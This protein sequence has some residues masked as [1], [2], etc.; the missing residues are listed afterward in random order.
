MSIERANFD[1]IAEAELNDLVQASVPEGLAIEYKREPYGNSDADKKEA[2]KDISSF[3]NSAGGHLIIGME[4]TNGVATGLRGLP[5]VDPDALITR[6]ESLVRDGVEPR[7]VGVR[8][9]AVRLGRGGAALVIRIPRSWNPPHRVSAARTNRF[10]VRNSGGAHEA[11]VEELRVLFTLAADARKRIETFR[12]HRLAMI[13][14]GAGPLPL[15]RGGRLIIHM[16]PLS[17]VSQAV[18]IDLER[19]FEARFQFRPMTSDTMTRR[20]NLDGVV[21]VNPRED[22][23]GYTQV[24]REGIVEAT[25]SN[26]L[27][28]LSPGNPVC[29]AKQ[30][31][32]EITE[33]IPGYLEGLQ[34]LD[35]PP[36]IVVLVSLQGVAGA[37][38]IVF[39]PAGTVEQLFPSSDPLILPDVV[40]DNYGSPR[41]YLRA[42]K[43]VFD[44]LW[45]AAGFARCM[46]YDADGNWLPQ[47]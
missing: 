47:R 35:V 19:A 15:S 36:P 22:R 41:D 42:L 18:A 12:T 23:P 6:L 25:L 39:N 16:I 3:A 7:I 33:V 24:F 9:R 29:E 11:S 26:I 1:D 38:L 34:A 31:T 14:A 37:K 10:Y 28:E 46:L 44:A 13:A 20:F 30:I 32:T 2:L 45:N 5:G 17:A 21:H 27:W 8:M 43:P 4:E 40:V